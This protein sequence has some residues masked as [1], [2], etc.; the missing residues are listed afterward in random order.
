MQTVHNLPLILWKEEEYQA[1]LL[2]GNFTFA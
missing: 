2:T 1:T